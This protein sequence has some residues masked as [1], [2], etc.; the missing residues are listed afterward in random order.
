MCKT[1][2]TSVFVPQL[3][4]L[5]ALGI[6]YLALPLGVYCQ[7]TY[8]LSVYNDSEVDSSYVNVYGITTT[9]DYSYGC[10]HSNFQTTNT[11]IT[12]DGRTSTLTLAGFSTTN[13][14][15]TQNFI[16]DF[17]SVGVLR[18]VC[19]CAG[20]VGAGGTGFTQQPTFQGCPLSSSPAQFA[21]V[22]C[23]G[24]NKKESSFTA[25]IPT[26]SPSACLM[27][28]PCTVGAE[29]VGPIEL[30]TNQ[31]DQPNPSC[32]IPLPTQLNGKVKY[33]AGPG[34]PQ[35]TIGQVKL[36][37]NFQ[38]KSQSVTFRKAVN[39]VCGN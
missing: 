20:L 8:S 22:D 21:D 31:S 10:Y 15:A 12:P 14:I 3:L 36:S 17:T 23:S 26:G 1:F 38:L 19:A 32:A 4:C 34:P 2:H 37:V 27:S 13:A 16:G 29:I 5:F 18:F 11:I 9:A 30:S 7:M 39:V 25:W 24:L 33:F 35:Q 6:I 28:I